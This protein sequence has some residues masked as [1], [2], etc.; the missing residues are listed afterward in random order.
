MENMTCNT[1]DKH[2]PTGHQIFTLATTALKLKS[3][4]RRKIVE[5]SKIS[6]ERSIEVSEHRFHQ[7]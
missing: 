5:L 6:P 3:G 7:L 1:E 4:S 2:P